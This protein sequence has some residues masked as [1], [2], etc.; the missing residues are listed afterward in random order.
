MTRVF[1]FALSILSVTL[2]G[3]FSQ[4]PAPAVDRSSTAQARTQP[5]GPGYYTVKRGDTL[6]RI[7]ME[8]GQDYRDIAA[9][10]NITNPAT[11]NEGQILRVIPPAATADSGEAVVAPI[12]VGGGVEA[13]SLDAPS[14]AAG[15]DGG[16]K[17]EP[18]VGKEPYSDEAYARLNRPAD[19]SP[20]PA[21]PRVEAKPEPAAPP[22][23][24]S[25]PDDVPWIWPSAGKVVAPFSDAGNKGLDFAGKAGDPVI[26]AGDG[27]V[28]YAGSGLRGYGE[29]VIIKHNA[30]FLSAYAH[31]RKILVKEGQQVARGQK[32]AEMGNT[33]ADTVKLH[34]EIRKQGKPVDP[35]QYLPKR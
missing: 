18:R 26:A 8:H 34:F 28:V 22:A 17:R 15:P 9:W 14:A 33:D 35:A 13:R 24:A 3:C 2:A 6:Y 25:G 29:L 12:G 5:S 11:I 1:L 31:N 30:T 19:T 7:A 20:R 10:N 32:I 21:E 16:P 4:Q 23:P 27:K